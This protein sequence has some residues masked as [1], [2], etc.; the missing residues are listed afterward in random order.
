MFTSNF[1]SIYNEHKGLVYRLA[2]SYLRNI[3]EAE[4]IT[5]MV[6]VK[7]HEKLDQFEGKSQL[8]TWIFKITKTTCLDSIKAKQRKKRKGNMMSFQKDN[9]ETIDI[10]D[11]EAHP[12][13]QLENQ[14]LGKYLFAAIDTLIEPQRTAFYLSQIDGMGNIEVAEILEK[15]VGAIESVVQRAKANLRKELGSFYEEYSRS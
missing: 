4:D 1:E 13:M 2:L 5:Q 7:V 15:S 12:G 14:E 8:K 11:M 3:E 10:K 6:F 9:G